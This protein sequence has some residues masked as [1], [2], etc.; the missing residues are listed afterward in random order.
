MRIAQMV[1][2]FLVCLLK[3]KCKYKISA[4]F[5]ETLTDSKDCSESRIKM[6]LLSCLP[7]VEKCSCFLVSHWSEN[8]CLSLVGKMFLLPCLSLVG[9]MFLLP[10][11]SLVG[12]NVPASL[13][14]H[15]YKNGPASLSLTGT[16]MFLLPC[17]SLVEKCS[18]FLV[19]HW[20]ENVPA[21]CFLVFRNNFSITASQAASG[22]PE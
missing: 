18:C 3:E 12:K 4:C 21:S 13:V 9:K 16:K 8:P 1:F 14:S 15:W 6:F 19:S 2:E 17:L 5:F 7:L 10:C 22:K 20:S 11:L